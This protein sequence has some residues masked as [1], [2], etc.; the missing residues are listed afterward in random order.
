MGFT[1][2]KELVPHLS[3]S[4]DDDNR[5]FATQRVEIIEVTESDTKVRWKFI[6]ENGVDINFQESIRDITN[7][8]LLENIKN[9]IRKTLTEENRIQM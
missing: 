5:L 2:L 4:K 8:E 3:L 1:N 6:L 7:K 9:Y